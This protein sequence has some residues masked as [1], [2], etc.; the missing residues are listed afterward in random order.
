MMALGLRNLVSESVTFSAGDWQIALPASNMGT[1]DLAEKARS[2]DA[3]VA[4]TTFRI[5][6]GA[7]VTAQVLCLV[8]H[9][10]SSAATIKWDR[11]SSAGGT[12]V[13]AGAA[14]NAWQITPTTYDGGQF[15]SFVIHAAATSAR[16]ETVTITDTTN[17]DGYVEIAYCWISPVYSTTYGPV[18]GLTHGVRDFSAKERGDG[19]SLWVTRRRRV[20]D[21]TL[22]LEAINP[23]EAAV[24]H[25]LQISQGSTEPVLYLPD[26]QVAADTQRYG[27]VGTLEELSNIEWP[28]HR[29]GRL[30]VRITEV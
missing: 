1:R 2:S 25:E 19:G 16:Y 8:G 13:V 26:T 15:A 20:R 30:P 23:T 18:T 17:A 3:L 4:S 9:N 21:V 22:A 14:T 29:M 24:L 10:L 5:D 7:A 27:F 11:G 6:H 28:Y 12:E